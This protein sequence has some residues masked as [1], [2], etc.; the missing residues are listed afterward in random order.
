[1]SQWTPARVVDF[2]LRFNSDFG[3]SLRAA[4]EG[5]KSASMP[6]E[7]QAREACRAIARGV[8]VATHAYVWA[9][10][11]MPVTA[12]KLP[13]DVDPS[14]G[15]LIHLRLH[16]NMPMNTPIDYTQGTQVQGLLQSLMGLPRGGLAGVEIGFPGA[17]EGDVQGPLLSPLNPRTLPGRSSARSAATPCPRTRPAARGCGARVEG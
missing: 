14:D 3:P 2:I 17:A 13:V 12:V 8:G 10:P 11:N 6:H 4:V 16:L 5:V 9:A 1:M 7:D 15:T